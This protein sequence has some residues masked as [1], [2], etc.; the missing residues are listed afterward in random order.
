MRHLRRYTMMVCL[1]LGVAAGALA[2]HWTVNPRAFQY[3]MTAYVRIDGVAQADCEVAA[4]CR[5]DDGQSE[6]RG[7]GKLLQLTDGTQVFQLRVRSNVASGEQIVFCVYHKATE[8]EYWP[9]ASIDFEAQAMA[10]TPGEP[11]VLSVETDFTLGDANGDGVVSIADVTAIINRINNMVTGT[12]VEAA[13]DVNG[14][15]IISIADVTGVINII[16]KT[17]E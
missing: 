5:A 3:D 1:L 4:L 14:D 6:C 11:I 2:Q 10:G 8:R 12:F 15:K 9:D 17:E 16:N 13:A 7:V